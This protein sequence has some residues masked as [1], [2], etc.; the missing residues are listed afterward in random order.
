[1]KVFF[2]YARQLWTRTFIIILEI[3]VVVFCWSSILFLAVDLR[4]DWMFS[5]IFNL[6]EAAKVNFILVVV[7]LFF[8]RL[9]YSYRVI[10]KLH[11][12]EFVLNTS[13]AIFRNHDALGP[14][15]TLFKLFIGCSLCITHIQIAVEWV[16]FE[17]KRCW[18][19]FLEFQF[20]IRY[21]FK[22]LW[23]LLFNFGVQDHIKLT[24]HIVRQQVDEPLK[25]QKRVVYVHLVLDLCCFVLATVEQGLH[26]SHAVVIKT[27]V[28]YE[29]LKHTLIQLLVA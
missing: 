2:K 17:F 19:C 18:I 16:L 10:Y 9:D 25:N 29:V 23:L 28:I 6:T 4:I 27:I 26:I 8:E 1:M 15:F 5:L 11:D 14:R 13:C 3:Q 12:Q 21:T 7:L 20:I 24:Q 22:W